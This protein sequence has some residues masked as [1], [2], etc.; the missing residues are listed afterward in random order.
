MSIELLAVLITA[1]FQSILSLIGFVM[2]YRVGNQKNA[3]EASLCLQAR[4]IQ[5]GMREIRESLRE[6]N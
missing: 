4:R 1:S 6:R 2:L 5:E 3:D